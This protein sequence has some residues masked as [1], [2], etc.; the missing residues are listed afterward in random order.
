MILTAFQTPQIVAIYKVAKSLSVLPIKVSFPVWRYLQPKFIR[1]ILTN[2]KNQTRKLIYYGSGLLCLLLAMIFPFVWIVG[3]KMITAFYGPAYQEAFKP[4]LILLLGI[5]AFNG[6]TGWFKIWAVVN[7]TQRFG[8][9][10]YFTMF[11]SLVTVGVLFG[12]E[13]PLEMS[14]AVSGIFVAFSVLVF[15]KL[16]VF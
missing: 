12:K 11:V 13:G 5:W 7:R 14:Y 9:L 4:L 8:L 2:D 3:Q 6:L 10:T 16:L 1:A 15:V